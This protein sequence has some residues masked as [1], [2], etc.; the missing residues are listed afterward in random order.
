M[1]DYER[2]QD[3]LKQRTLQAQHIK[4][5]SDVLNFIIS[6]KA[7]GCA[8]DLSFSQNQYYGLCNNYSHPWNQYTQLTN[9]NEL[10]QTYLKII[11][12]APRIDSIETYE[13][14]CPDNS[15]N[16]FSMSTC[17]DDF[18]KH[19]SYIYINDIDYIVFY[20][21]QN[22]SDEIV[23]F[24]LNHN[25]VNQDISFYPIYEILEQFNNS[26][27]KILLSNIKYQ[28]IPTTNSPLPNVDICTCASSF[29]P[30]VSLW[31]RSPFTRYQ[32]S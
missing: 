21:K 32:T 24:T 3:F 1:T 5:L 27:R 11:K 22:K 13:M 28:N 7:D 9:K 12:L 23:H 31:L 26:I 8:L 4:F 10:M 17:F 20:G 15:M 18:C 2:E 6:K 25:G 14:A 29:L 19:I 30:S 16:K